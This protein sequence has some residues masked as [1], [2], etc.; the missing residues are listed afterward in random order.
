MKSNRIIGEKGESIACQYLIE[1]G[2]TLIEKNWTAGHKEIDIICK[3]DELYVFVEV[4]TRK[5]LKQGLPEESIS[6]Q[7]IKSVT[8]AA[9]VY[10]EN[11]KYK[12]IRFDVISIILKNENQ[13]E[14]L[15]IKD[16][17]Y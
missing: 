4:K 9:L 7:K 11:K 2:Y 5:V 13:F 8:D 12:D 6:E 10:L 3:E 1:Q 15:H 16:A 14:L 17:F